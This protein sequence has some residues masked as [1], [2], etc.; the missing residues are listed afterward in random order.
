MKKAILAVV[1]ILVILVAI[2]LL[3]SAPIDPAAYAPPKAPDLT[4][5]LAP[6]HLLQKAELLARGKINGPEE[7]AVLSHPC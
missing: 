5:V 1:G 7:V 4:G 3:Q 6:N 2:F